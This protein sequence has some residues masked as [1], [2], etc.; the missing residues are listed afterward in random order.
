MKS[1][2]GVLLACLVMTACATRS[3]GLDGI[4]LGYTRAQVVQELGAPNE[5]HEPVRNL[6]GQTIDVFEYCLV[7]PSES[8]SGGIL[9]SIAFLTL[10]T[11][12]GTLSRRRKDVWLYFIDDDLVKCGEAGNWREEAQRIHRVR[13]APRR[14]D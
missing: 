10:G 4:R 14:A 5:V 7:E 11:G 13:F 3:S 8:P 12:S 2:P 9:N 6:Y 1:L